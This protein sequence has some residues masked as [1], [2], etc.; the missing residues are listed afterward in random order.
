MK[1]RILLILSIALTTSQHSF[2]QIINE[3]NAI[4]G[5]VEI[6]NNT[7]S[8]LD[9]SSYFLCNFPSYAQLSSLDLD[10]GSLIIPAGDFVVVSGFNILG[11][12][13][14][15]GL[16]TVPSYGDSNAIISYVEWGSTG[17]FRSSTAVGAGIWTTGWFVDSPMVGNWIALDGNGVEVDNWINVSETTECAANVVVAA[18]CEGG[19]VSTTDGVTAVSVC[20]MDDDEDILEFFTTSESEESFQYIITDE[21]NV[22]LGLPGDS[23]DFNEAPAGVCRV[24]GL[25]YA[26]V[27]ALQP[28]D[29]MDDVVPSDDCWSMSENFIE[30]TRTVVDGGDVFLSDESTLAYACFG[31]DDTIYSFINN[32]TSDANYVYVV[33]ESGIILEVIVGN[34]NNF[35]FM[36][37]ATCSIYGI[38]YT[39]DFLLG[40]GMSL[41]DNDA[42]TGCFDI[43][44]TFATVITHSP[45]GGMVAANGMDTT[46]VCT[47]QVVDFTS[48]SESIL[49]YAYAI[50]NTDNELLAVSNDDSFD[51]AMM[52]GGTY[53]VYGLSYANMITLVDNEFIFDTDASDQCFD[54]SAQ[55]AVVILEE[56]EGGLALLSNED[57]MIELCSLDEDEDIVTFQTTS[58]SDANYNY[59]ITDPDGNV[60]GLPAANSNDFNEAPA[61]TCYIYG[62]SYVGD[63]VIEVG[64]NIF[65]DMISDGC[66]M[67]SENFITVVRHVVTGGAVETTDGETT[68][69]I[70]IDGTADVISFAT[71]S[72]S[73]EDYTYIVTDDA[74]NILAVLG[75]NSNDFDPAGAGECHL[76]GVS[77]WGDLTAEVGT[78][79]DDISA[80]G[81]FELSSNFVTVIREVFDNVESLSANEIS[82]YPNPAS[83]FITLNTSELTNASWSVIDQTGRV[84]LTGLVNSSTETI[85]LSQLAKGVYSIQLVHNNQK[86]ISTFVIN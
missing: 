78:S 7:D 42:S 86:N 79:I 63:L 66:G 24:W 27:L 32:S 26:G 69:N 14:E 47:G 22:I 64:Q 56:V 11:N 6:Y 85:S 75:D 70:V 13:G 73:D 9:V 16:Y 3:I 83:D 40:N 72:D 36:A 45:E 55:F 58:S 21:D 2:G 30:V 18:V 20:S 23:N 19:I 60:L 50:T 44:D 84:V 77:H 76:Y 52:D 5:Q 4:S 65:A 41:F 74:E 43:S 53:Y 39:G 15:C 49:A 12:D 67:L 59:I 61:G 35:G 25:S 17:H 48:T 51:F 54:W 62:F 38:S 57:I 80:E 10:C 68:I 82:L 81:C 37:E 33:V 1:L 8:E 29:D 31:D 28:G 46:Y 34:S 71:D